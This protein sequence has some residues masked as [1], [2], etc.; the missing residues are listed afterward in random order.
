MIA[1]FAFRLDPE[2]RNMR[3]EID[4]PNPGERLYPGMYAEVSLAVDRRPDVLTVPSSAV[5]ADG[6]GTFVYT[7]KDGRIKRLAVK[8]GLGDNG[9]VEVVEG[10]SGEAAVVMTAKGAPPPGATLLG[11]DKEVVPLYKGER[12][13]RVLFHA[14]RALMR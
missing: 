5:G 11:L 14:L 7:V 12:D 9:Q 3:T 2:T 1:R 10:L 6:D 8:T 4:L 13:I